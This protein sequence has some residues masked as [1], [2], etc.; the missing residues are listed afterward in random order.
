[1]LC[2]HR[3]QVY[4]VC[5]TS[6]VGVCVVLYIGCRCMYCVVLYALH[7]CMYGMVLYVMCGCM[8]CDVHCV[9]VYVIEEKQRNCVF[10]MCGNQFRVCIG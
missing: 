10:F 7:G 8:H 2:V 9:Y 5:C 1:M 3:V 4:V 6:G